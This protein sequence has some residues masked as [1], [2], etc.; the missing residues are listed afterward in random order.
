M[1]FRV[2]LIVR[3]AKDFLK[4]IHYA[5]FRHL[6]KLNGRYFNNDTI[7]AFLNSEGKV[8]IFKITLY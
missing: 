5:R 1:K 6:F 7:Y 4:I 8:Y 3:R 2:N